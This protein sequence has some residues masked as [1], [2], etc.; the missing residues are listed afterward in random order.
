MKHLFLVAL[1]GGIGASM[2]YM[3]GV[4]S[5]RSFGPAF[6]YGTMIVN[7]LG[8]FIMGVMIVAIA[9]RFDASASLQLFLATGILGGFTT[10]SAFS[11]DALNLLEK[12]AT[13]AA[14]AYIALSVAGAL[15]AC[16]LGLIIGRMVF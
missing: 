1:G 15:L 9:R 14:F 2:R 3:V 13:N 6:P 7:L 5:L 16:F 4:A 11:L 10:F 8:S 12:G